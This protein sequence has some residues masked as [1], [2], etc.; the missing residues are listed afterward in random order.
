MALDR[1]VPPRAFRSREGPL[2]CCC[3]WNDYLGP[4]FGSLS[5]GRT[6]F[7]EIMKSKTDRIT[8]SR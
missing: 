8:A 2:S 7:L 5:M 1:G 4:S 6:S 3:G